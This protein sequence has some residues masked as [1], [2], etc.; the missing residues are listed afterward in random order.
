[1]AFTQLLYQNLYSQIVFSKYLIDK[2]WVSLTAECVHIQFLLFSP[3]PVCF[4]NAK[5]IKV[6]APP[7]ICSQLTHSAAKAAIGYDGNFHFKFT[8]YKRGETGLS[9]VRFWAA[10]RS[11]HPEMFVPA[12]V[13]PL[14][15][16]DISIG[17]S[18]LLLNKNKL[19]FCLF[20]FLF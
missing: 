3:N 5:T 14:P 7:Q 13:V 1:M 17:H 12:E 4:S 6:Q 10:E 15:D 19:F 18:R 16:T 11:T 8:W 20:V 9:K 2:L